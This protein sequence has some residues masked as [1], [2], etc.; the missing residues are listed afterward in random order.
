MKG[1][2]SSA[3][4][5]LQANPVTWDN[6]QRMGD[7]GSATPT[8]INKARRGGANKRKMKSSLGP[9]AFN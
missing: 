6:I 7:G 8:G 3:G 5:N 1:V 2:R 9:A 4:L